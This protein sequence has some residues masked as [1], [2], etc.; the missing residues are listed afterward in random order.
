MVIYLEHLEQAAIFKGFIL[1]IYLEQSG[2][3]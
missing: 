3:P 2:T 1:N